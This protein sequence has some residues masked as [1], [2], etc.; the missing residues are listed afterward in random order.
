[1]PKLAAIALLF[2][3]PLLSSEDK[4]KEDPKPIVVL[5]D[6]TKLAIR[7][8]QV[9]FLQNQ[10]TMLQAQQQV[11]PLQGALSDAVTKAQTECGGA[12]IDA[13]LNCTAPPISKPEA[14]N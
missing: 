13:N 14:K 12:Q 1:M 5:S 7:E 3:L 4:K 11:G 8:A 10:L 6:K 2:V 9:A